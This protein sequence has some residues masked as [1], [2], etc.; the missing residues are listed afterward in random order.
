M[1]AIS[2]YEYTLKMKRA[3]NTKSYSGIN[4]AFADLISLVLCS[5]IDLQS[6][7][8]SYTKVGQHS[9]LWMLF[10]SAPLFFLPGFIDLIELRD[11]NMQCF[12]TIVE[13]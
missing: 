8:F 13:I 4:R 5:R 2:Q 7:S 1:E 6:M 9:V 3:E 10:F 11:K 12:S